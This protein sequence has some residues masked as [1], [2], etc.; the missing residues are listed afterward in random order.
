MNIQEKLRNKK[1]K[2]KKI[3]SMLESEID[4][5]IKYLEY[6]ERQTK[7]ENDIKKLVEQSKNTSKYW[8]DVG[9]GWKKRINK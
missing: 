9:N 4:S 7:L 2:L 6:K 1:E 3:Q 8:I 5:Q